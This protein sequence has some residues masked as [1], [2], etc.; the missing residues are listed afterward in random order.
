MSY[1]TSSLIPLSV[2]NTYQLI[3]QYFDHP[4]LEKLKDRDN[5]SVYIAKIKTLLGGQEQ[6]YIIVTTFRDINAPGTKTPLKDLIW[7]S[8]QT[9]SLPDGM[10]TNKHSYVPKNDVKYQIPVTLSKRYEDHTDYDMNNETYKLSV[11]LLHKNKNLYS[12]PEKGTVSACLE[13]FQTIVTV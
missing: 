13:T 2:R 5:L 8:F 9:R 4:I 11:T 6:R 7:K 1:Q 3:D 10:T 12:Y